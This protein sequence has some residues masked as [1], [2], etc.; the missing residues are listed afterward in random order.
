MWRNDAQHLCS[1][2][3]RVHMGGTWY[4][5]YILGKPDAEWVCGRQYFSLSKVGMH[6]WRSTSTLYGKDARWW[7]LFIRFYHT[8]LVN[9][10]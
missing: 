9:R 7:H 6:T 8:K 2:C 10:L 5:R 4:Y 3:H 1:A